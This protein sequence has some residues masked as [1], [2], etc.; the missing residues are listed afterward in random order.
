MEAGRMDTQLAERTE[1]RQVARPPHVLVPLIKRDLEQGHEAANRASV[2]YYR[3]A[4]EKMIEAKEQLKHGEFQ[5]WL[6]RHFTISY[7]TA[8]RYM[9]FVDAEK[10]QARV[11]SSINSALKASGNN[12]YMPN[13]PR[14]QPW[15]EPVKE[16]IDR[17]KR[18]QERVTRLYADEITKKQEREAQRDLSLRLIDIGYKV[19]AKELHPDKGG[20]REIMARLNKAR[21]HLKQMA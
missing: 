16:I 3:A 11:F 9:G 7:D 6:K 2:P 4:G 19:L 20:S 21:D 1:K 18:E 14:P 10:T 15:H 8:R 12:G 5:P 13:K 17:T